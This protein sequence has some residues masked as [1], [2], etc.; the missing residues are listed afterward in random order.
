MI[1]IRIALTAELGSLRESINE[2]RQNKMLNKEQY[3][4]EDINQLRNENEMLTKRVEHLKQYSRRENV[5][6]GTF[7]QRMKN[8]ETYS[9]L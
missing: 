7:N 3:F 8:L 2:I 1:E 4:Q 5:I 6:S 9:K